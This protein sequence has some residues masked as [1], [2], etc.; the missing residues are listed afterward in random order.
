M[1]IV[2]LFL[3]AML[4][5]EVSPRALERS[6]DEGASASELIPEACSPKFWHRAVV[7]GTGH[8]T[9]F[10]TEARQIGR[11]RCDCTVIV[12]QSRFCQASIVSEDEALALDPEQ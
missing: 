6:S 3:I 7:V 2:V 12:G 1:R 5:A 9:N 10:E 8:G 4:I 11:I